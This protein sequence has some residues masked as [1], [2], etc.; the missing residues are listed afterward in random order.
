M[1]KEEAKKVLKEYI[2]KAEGSASEWKKTVAFRQENKSWLKK[3][4]KIAIKINRSLRAQKMTQKDLADLLKVSPQ[5]VN[6]ILKGSE[7]LTL[8][9][10]VKIEDKLNIELISILKSNEV[11]VA[12]PSKGFVMAT[13][14]TISKIYSSGSEILYKEDVYLVTEL[15]EFYA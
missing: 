12:M 15:E 6:K 11:I 3:S 9:T 10:I 7:N 4:A 2:S 8:E 14:N 1:A 5:M 13:S